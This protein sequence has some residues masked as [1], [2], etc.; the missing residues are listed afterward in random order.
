MHTFYIKGGIGMNYN[1]GYMPQN[2]G[3]QPN[4]QQA[5]QTPPAMADFGFMG[6][7]EIKG[8]LVLPNRTL[9]AIDRANKKLYIKS[10][11]GL[12]VSTIDTYDLTKS[13][14]KTAQP[15]EYITRDEFSK[16]M[17]ELREMIKN[18]QPK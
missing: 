15:V 13:V 6:E 2:F 3:Y 5:Q 11:D 10:T 9:Y 12:G 17:E 7:N 18:E 1:N 14:D 4:Y 16:E 8:Y